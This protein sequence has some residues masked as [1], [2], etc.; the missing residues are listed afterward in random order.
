MRTFS[1]F[2]VP[3][4]LAALCGCAEREFHQA[5]DL[6]PAAACAPAPLA[7]ADGG[8]AI[9]AYGCATADNLQAMLVNPHDLETG[10]P[11]RTAPAGDA[12]VTPALR[13]RLDQVKPLPTEQTPSATVNLVNQTH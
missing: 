10:A 4:S 8:S 6:K 12:A 9:P 7:G 2:L 11:P 13:Y 3:A 1:L 5:D